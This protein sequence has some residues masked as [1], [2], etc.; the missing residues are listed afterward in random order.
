MIKEQSCWL[1][2]ASAWT[3]TGGKIPDRVDVVVVGGGYTGLAAARM[4]AR[5]GASVAVFEKRRAGEC[6][7]ARNGGQV[8]TGLKL[9][10]GELI[11]AF[12][13]QRARTLFAASLDAIDYLE[14]LIEE[15]AIACDYQR[16]GHIEAAAKPSH[17]E[18]FKA[19]Q[20]TLAREFDHRVELVPASA[21]RAEVVSDRYHG[22]LVDARSASIHPAKYLSGLA[23]AATSAGARLYDQTAVTQIRRQG[24]GFAVEVRSGE[25][26]AS[27]R[28]SVAA[29]DV[30]ACTGGDT[31]RALPALGRRIVPIGSYV[32]ATQPLTPA[33]ATG[34]LPRRRVAFDSRYFLSYFRLSSD[35]RLVFGGRAQFTPSTP[36]STRRAAAI[37]ERSMLAVF[38]QLRGTR[39]EYAWSGNVDFTMDMLPHA[40]IVDGVHFAIGYGGHGIA[41]ATYLGTRV[42][43]CITG[44]QADT[45]FHDLRFD[46][47]PLYTGKPWFLPLAGLYYR[48]KDWRS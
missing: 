17:F 8:L 46:A 32:I 45:P 48:W 13:R 3:G 21:Q 40:G 43:E 30:V 2:D 5:S 14:E 36:S 34:V 15:E 12:G 25:S 28:Q 47:L 35:N 20:S 6:A 29:R 31:D 1:D 41:L 27:R 26:G 33:Q 39:V 10:A 9:G 22:L 7:S 38:P 11:Q 18:H 37:L 42:A 24:V 19:E 16:V 4:L 44:K 23:R